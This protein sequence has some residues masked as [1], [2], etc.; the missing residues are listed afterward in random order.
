MCLRENKAYSACPA[1]AKT[2]IGNKFI[3]SKEYLFVKMSC[4]VCGN[5]FTNLTG[6]DPHMRLYHVSIR[7]ID[8]QMLTYQSLKT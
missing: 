7:F 4:T 3:K 2:E 6:I 8:K 5:M 1:G